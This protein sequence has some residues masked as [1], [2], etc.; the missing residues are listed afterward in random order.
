MESGVDDHYAEMVSRNL[1]LVTSREQEKLKTAHVFIPGVGGYGGACI[2]TLVRAGVTRFTIADIDEFETSNLNRQVFAFR[3]TVGKSKVESTVERL[4]DINPD[5]DI[6]VYG[7]EWCDRL[8]EILP[9]SAIVAN[10]MDDLEACVRLYRKAREHRV[11]V[12]DGYMA[13]LPSVT[14]VAPEDPRPEER[15]GFPT[16][17]K[18]PGEITDAMREAAKLRELEYV[19]VHS[20]SV[21]HVDLAMASEF[22]SGRRIRPSFAPSVITT[23]NLMAFEVISHV[24]GRTT[25]TDC[26]GYFFNPWS[27]KVERP[28]GALLAA[29]L[30]SFARRF[31]KKMTRE[32]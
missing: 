28:K 25:R 15:L 13:P 31:M 29:I 30:T 4:K 32:R 9:S 21:K 20:S 7:K 27:G 23:G 10:G 17:G 19:M 16:I 5:L 18:D 26:R 14:R 2:Q 24:I 8:D 11:T 6:T 1:G 3:S 22:V 12:V